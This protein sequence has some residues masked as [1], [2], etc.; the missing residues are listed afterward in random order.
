[1]ESPF[2]Y[3]D[4]R[5]HA[6]AAI[7]LAKAFL[8]LLALK[9]RGIDFDVV[10]VHFATE[11]FLMRFVRRAF[12]WPYVFVLEG[13]T[14]LEAK[15]AKAANAAIA[16]S[17]DIVRRCEAAQGFKP[18]KLFVGIDRTR[19]SPA[20]GNVKGASLGKN[21]KQMILCVCRLEPRKDIP[22][23]LAA[24]KQV[25]KT[26]DARLVIVGNGLLRDH[27][28]KMVDNMGLSK[29][30]TIDSETEY[31]DLPAYYQSADVFSM[32]T[33]YEG[34]GIVFLEAMSSGVPIVSTRV[35]AIPEILD[36]SAVLVPPRDPSALAHALVRVLTDDT[37]KSQLVV[38]G[39][40]TVS[41]FDWKTLIEDYEQIYQRV[42][43]SAK[44][45]T[46]RSRGRIRL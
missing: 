3:E 1:M 33:L 21:G 40:R 20:H 36:S 32:S 11:A 26:V 37:L 16:I 13:Y 34:L 24:M 23:L 14:G 17:D 18:R 19:F 39:N 31:E 28:T 27:L 7:F 35:G 2:S 4:S 46:E 6:Y 9:L 43:S 44:P 5:Q 45:G 22:T 42:A 15:E 38:N 30:V 8:R 25:L 41:R 10:S 12:G 29:S